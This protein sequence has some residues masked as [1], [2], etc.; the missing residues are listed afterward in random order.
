MRLDVGNILT[1]L[2][3]ANWAAAAVLAVEQALI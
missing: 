1:K 2:D 3:A